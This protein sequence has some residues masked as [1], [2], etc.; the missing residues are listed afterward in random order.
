MSRPSSPGP[1][2]L[3]GK[4]MEREWIKLGSRRVHRRIKDI[5]DYVR[6]QEK[7]V[8]STSTTKACVDGKNVAEVSGKGNGKKGVEIS[9]DL[10]QPTLNHFIT[11]MKKKHCRRATAPVD[12]HSQWRMSGVPASLVSRGVR[13]KAASVSN[14]NFE[15]QTNRSSAEN[16][17]NINSSPKKSGSELACNGLPSSPSHEALPIFP[18]SSSYEVPLLHEA[19]SPFPLLLHDTDTPLN[20]VHV[21]KVNSITMFCGPS[22]IDHRTDSIHGLANTMS[23]SQN[24]DESLAYIDTDELLAELSYCEKIII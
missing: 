10:R 7:L 9:T 6:V 23:S 15:H 17:E 18:L 22:S 20:Q 5:R 14:D 13:K 11:K 4:T 3:A 24:T 1:Q 21:D 8:R 12:K 2:K 19:S 16:K